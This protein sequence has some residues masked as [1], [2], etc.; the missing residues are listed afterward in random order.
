VLF[1]Y[2]DR[3]A[4]VDPLARPLVE[5]DVHVADADLYAVGEQ[6]VAADRH[7]VRLVRV[8][9]HAPSKPGVIPDRDRRP[10]DRVISRRFRMGSSQIPTLQP[11]AKLIREPDT[12]QFL[13][14]NT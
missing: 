1:A 7:V 12:V 6:A 11:P 2:Y 10:T 5:D 13:R 9:A 8:D 3:P 14:M 4:E